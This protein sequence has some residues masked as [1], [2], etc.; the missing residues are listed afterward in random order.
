MNA[1]ELIGTILQF[2]FVM[3][4]IAGGY[5]CIRHR[6]IEGFVFFLIMLILE[7]FQYIITKGME[8]WMRSPQPIGALSIGQL[9]QLL[10]VAQFLLH[11]IAFVTLVVGLYRRFRRR[12]DQ[13][14]PYKDTFIY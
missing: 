12:A 9:L 8:G 4:L 14:I 1:I 10:T 2:V 5:L 7:I 6:F 13:P 3:S 11:T